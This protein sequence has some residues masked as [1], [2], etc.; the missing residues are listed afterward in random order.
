MSTSETIS[1]IAVICTLSASIGGL[2]VWMV[3][4]VWARATMEADQADRIRRVE[5]ELE[6]INKRIDDVS[7]SSQITSLR[8]EIRGD[9]R[10]MRESFLSALGEVE[11]RLRAVELGF[12]ARPCARTLVDCDKK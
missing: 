10:E 6:R 9:I 11:R 7:D 8:D 1:L 5:I 4:R 3:S 2:I 12:A